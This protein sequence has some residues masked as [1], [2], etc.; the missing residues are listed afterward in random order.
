MKPT[1]IVRRIDDLGRIVL[2][3]ELRRSLCLQPDSPMEMGVENGM[4][5]LKPYVPASNVAAQIDALAGS[6]REEIDFCP[7]EDE[8]RRCDSAI[9]L[10]RKARDILNAKDAAESLRLAAADAASQQK[11]RKNRVYCVFRTYSPGEFTD[12]HGE[13]LNQVEELVAIYDDDKKA[14]ERCREL[15]L[16]A[17]ED[18]AKF[19]CDPETYIVR[20]GPVL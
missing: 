2:P 12:K 5:W 10:L 16:A 9:R 17:K 8:T 15:N 7:D 4:I 19:D 1:G 11:R 3:K 6:L 13:T 18:T 20:V 14:D